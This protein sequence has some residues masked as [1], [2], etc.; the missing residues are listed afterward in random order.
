VEQDGCD[1]CQI[2][3]IKSNLEGDDFTVASCVSL[4]YMEHFK[5]ASETHPA[6]LLSK[7]SALK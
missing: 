4:D 6:W 1:L 3:I 2:T 5:S 7:W